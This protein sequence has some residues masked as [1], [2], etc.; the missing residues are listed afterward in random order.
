MV[1]LYTEAELSLMPRSPSEESLQCYLLVF[2]KHV[3]TVK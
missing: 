3:Y 1:Y 2:I